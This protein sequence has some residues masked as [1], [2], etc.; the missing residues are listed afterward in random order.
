MVNLTSKSTKMM[1]PNL[2]NLEY[3]ATFSWAEID[4]LN[5]ELCQTSHKYITFT[6]CLDIPYI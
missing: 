2:V 4:L 6:M 1:N 5:V 3:L